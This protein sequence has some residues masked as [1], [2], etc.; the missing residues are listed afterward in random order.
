MVGIRGILKLK[1]QKPNYQITTPTS[2]TAEIENVKLHLHYNVQPWVGVL[3]WTPKMEL[4]AWKMMKG[5]VSKAFNFPALKVK[6]NTAK[7]APTS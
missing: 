3:T 6:E 2:K 4:G 1:N 5:G 7:K